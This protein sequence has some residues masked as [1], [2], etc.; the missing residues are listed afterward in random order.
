MKKI[1]SLCILIF[2]AYFFAGPFIAL[3]GLREALITQ[4]KGSLE[5]YV[6]FPILRNNIKDQ[7]NAQMAANAMKE[8]DDNPFGAAAAGFASLIVD[9]MVDRFL[10]PSGVAVL[11]SGQRADR[12]E[13]SS[14]NRGLTEVLDDV[15]FSFASHDRFI[16]NIANDEGANV[17][18][19]L[20]REWLS[21]RLTDI[22]IPTM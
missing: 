16:I 18:A 12:S 1:V 14:N 21:W 5:H 22:E 15:S 10:T 13:S 3:H 4:D 2:L 9:G 20:K 17:T 8:L 11:L 6:D 7:L 19:T